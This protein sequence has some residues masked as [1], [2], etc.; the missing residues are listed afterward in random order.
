MNTAYKIGKV[1]I[2]GLGTALLLSLS[3][4]NI[5]NRAYMPLNMDECVQ[6]LHVGFPFIILFL[7]I[8]GL[9][10]IVLSNS[11]LRYISP[12]VVVAAAAL[13]CLIMGLILIF[14]VDP[15]ARSDAKLCFEAATGFIKSDYS[16]LEQGG[17]L[18]ENAH[19]IGFVLYDML[20]AHISQDVR[21]LYFMN[22]VLTII[23]NVLIV[24]LTSVMTGGNRESV[25]IAALLSLLFLPQLNF[26][27]FGYNQ[28]VSITL[29][30]LSSVNLGRFLRKHGII[31]MF[32]MI[33]TSYLAV[34]V[35]GNAAIFVIAEIIIVLMHFL[36]R[37]G[38]AGKN[39]R[40]SRE[41]DYI[42]DPEEQAA[43]PR[44]NTLCAVAAV[45]LLCVM[46][47]AGPSMRL[48]GQKVTGQTLPKELPKTMWIAMGMQDGPRAAGWYNGYLYRTYRESN[49]DMDLTVSKARKEI[50]DRMQVFLGNPGLM[51][52]FYSEKILSTWSEPTFE[53]IWS[54]PLED[55]GQH[56][57]GKFLNAL[58]TGGTPYS[59]FC[60]FSAVI[61]LLIFIGGGIGMFVMLT[62]LVRQ[63]TRLRNAKDRRSKMLSPAS[64]DLLLLPGLVLLGGFFFHILWETKSQYVMFYV[65]MLIPLTSFGY[66]F[67]CPGAFTSAS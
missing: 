59:L 66:A 51:A 50:S 15:A 32:L 17:Y 38:K 53:S 34:C 43:S 49:Y 40:P 12:Q 24:R 7:F 47:L 16:S 4:M 31:S 10:L 6:Y 30:L 39:T 20:L 58:Y 3:F 48:A 19:Q 35:R 29:M 2:Q 21:F 65:Y 1:I 8:F 23:N 28:T 14:H 56:M 25:T 41:E 5:F 42:E 63:R 18:F 54:G 26:I 46:L 11:L 45:I 60:G 13:I 44:R 57:K 36:R 33:V 9:F 62:G 22:L 52:F 64:L 27:L 67:I 61:N 37:K 55:M